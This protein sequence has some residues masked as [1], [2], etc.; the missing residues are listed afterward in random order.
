MLIIAMT[1]L[2]ITATLITPVKFKG[3]LKR[4]CSRSMI[5]LFM[6]QIMATV[7]VVILR[8][9]QDAPPGPRVPRI[10]RIE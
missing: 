1:N 4:V 9:K 5:S 7:T 2:V 10:R 8:R 6:I 3:V